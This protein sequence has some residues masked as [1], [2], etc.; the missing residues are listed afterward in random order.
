MVRKILESIPDKMLRA[1]LEK[2]RQRA[3]ELGA[4]EAKIVTTDIIVFDERAQAKC[5]YPRCQNYGTSV[6]CPPHVPEISFFEKLV[7]RYQ[8]GIF[9]ML[10]VPA[11]EIAGEEALEKGL[12]VKS[13]R[14]VYEIV[15]KIES[16]AFY[17]GYELAI[18]FTAGPCK[19][20]FCPDVECSALT[21]GQPCRYPLKA[22]ASMDSTGMRVYLMAA[23]M[24]WDI[25]PVGRSSKPSDIP[26]GT[27]LG[28][29][30]I[31]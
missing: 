6:N 20:V 25:Y 10:K 21:P 11:G 27:R 1:D 13:S 2:Y 29:V 14:K 24:G 26:H 18:G 17:D 30:L 5:R 23:K 22:R 31:H 15:G 12:T 7:S 4:T 8:H 9:F 3:L 28:L 19:S 16:E